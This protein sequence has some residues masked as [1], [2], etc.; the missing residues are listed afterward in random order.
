VA[1]QAQDASNGS[2]NRELTILKR[3]FSL[4]CQAGKLLVRPHIPLRNEANARTGFFE[5]EQIEAVLRHLR[6]RSSL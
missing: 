1:R 4:A 6:P 5:P 2:I 3:T